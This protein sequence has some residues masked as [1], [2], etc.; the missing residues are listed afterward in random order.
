MKVRRNLPAQERAFLRRSL[1]TIA[2]RL[3][4]AGLSSAEVDALVR[5][6]LELVDGL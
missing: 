4:L 1:Q 5:P 6:F 2:I 3:R